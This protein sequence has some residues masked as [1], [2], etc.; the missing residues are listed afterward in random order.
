VR[1]NETYQILIDPAVAP[2]SVPR[3]FQVPAGASLEDVAN[4]LYVIFDADAQCDAVLLMAAGQAA[5]VVTRERFRTLIS[6]SGPHRGERPVGAGDGASLAGQ[7]VDYQ[8]FTYCC[9]RCGRV[10]YLMEADMPAPD[11]E[12]PGHGKM[13][14]EA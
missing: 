2:D 13:E 5:G 1:G 4:A 10:M 12:E 7:P 3:R 14:R 11:C 6:P 9:Q 8:V